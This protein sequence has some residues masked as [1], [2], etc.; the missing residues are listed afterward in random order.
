M[1]LI[2]GM[3]KK[4]SAFSGFSINASPIKNFEWKLFLMSSSSSPL[5]SVIMPVRNRETSVYTAIESV[6]TQTY[7][8]L[9][10]IVVDDGSSDNTIKVLSSCTDCR[11]VLLRNK[12]P[13]GAAVSRNIGIKKARGSLIAFNDSDDFW[14][15][16][17][18]KLAVD[19]LT[20]K[21]EVVGVFSDAIQVGPAMC[22]I[23]PKHK[24]KYTEENQFSL[25]LW[26]NLVDT[27]SLTVRAQTLKQVGGFTP[28]LPRFQDWDLALRICQIGVLHYLPIPLYL[29]NI[30]E[31]SI[32][33]DLNARA[34]ALRYIY[35]DNV[36]EIRTNR[37]LHSNWLHAIGDSMYKSKYP[38]GAVGYLFSAYILQP[39]NLK[40]ALK[41][42][43][44]LFGNR[45]Y[46]SFTSF[47][48]PRI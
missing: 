40:F 37:E 31:G 35:R 41:A 7:K 23:L 19:V 10:L 1:P 18:L 20:S 13:R 39:M 4:C 16:N 21:P 33:G 22:R 12:S 26:R 27:P 36:D 2:I 25:L 15:H 47:R 38:R 34:V 44:S 24:K 48:I 45:I 30:T 32:T 9:E 43:L 29:S 28:D 8:N 11:L 5:V 3:A 6:L 14:F 17:R 42:V 46:V